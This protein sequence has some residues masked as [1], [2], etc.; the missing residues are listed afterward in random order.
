M[1]C[2][3]FKLDLQQQRPK[4]FPHVP[5]QKYP[6]EDTGAL[7]FNC[8]TPNSSPS[9]ICTARVSFTKISFAVLQ[10]SILHQGPLDGQNER[11]VTTYPQNTRSYLLY[12]R[13]VLASFTFLVAGFFKFCIFMK[14]KSLFSRCINY[15]AVIGKQAARSLKVNVYLSNEVPLS[16]FSLTLRL[17]KFK[18]CRK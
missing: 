8:I 6:L 17:C 11:L 15:W 13:S 12:Q 7:S 16:A 10:L 18:L 1:F 14:S 3:F 5:A 9:N 2:F 4:N